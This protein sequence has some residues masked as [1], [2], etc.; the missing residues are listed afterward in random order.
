MQL[1]AAV[2]MLLRR[3]APAGWEALLAGLFLGLGSTIKTV[4]A[5]QWLLLAAWLVV[6]S[7]KAHAAEKRYR[8]TITSL[9]M[10]GAGP[11]LVWAAVF[12]YFAVTG[13]FA[14]FY[15]AVFQF[16]LSY[17]DV[18]PA[19]WQRFVDF[20]RAPVHRHVAPRYIEESPKEIG[21]PNMVTAVLASYRG[22][23]TLGETTV[24]FTAGIAV[25]ALLGMRRLRRRNGE[26]EDTD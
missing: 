12:G 10:F 1:L 14:E 4:M 25:L 15:E 6:W 18:A 16:N 21:I 13:R 3:D 2:W 17:S 9:L 11:A 26:S 7:W 24:I 22:Y 8:A 20:F 23:D 19:Y 5:A